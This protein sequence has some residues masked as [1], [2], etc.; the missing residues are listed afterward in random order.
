MFPAKL[1]AVIDYPDGISCIDTEQQR[2][3]LACCYLMRSGDQYAFIECGTSLSVPGLKA[4]LA[5]RGIGLD[6]IAYVIPTHVHLDHAGGVGL[7][8]KDCPNAKLVV[9]PRGARHLIDPSALI[10]GATA[11]YGPENMATMYG[12]ILPVAEDR[13]I[14]ADDNYVLDFNGRK[15]SFIDSPGHARHHF[16][17]WDVQSGGWF[18][19]DTFGLSYRLFDGPNGPFLMPTTTPVQFEPEAWLKTLSRYLAADPAF[20]FLT[21]YGRVDNVAQLAADLGGGIAM[22][23][24]IALHLAEVPDRHARIYEA[25][26]LYSLEELAANASPVTDEVAREWLAFDIELN[27]QGLEVWLDKQKAKPAA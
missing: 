8:M 10:A 11:V 14:V 7:L 6:Q 4:V 27:T 16:S 24:S 21:H 17:I 23:Q 15:L 3:G 2:T 1:P 5:E 18:T 22:Y 19:G 9:H 25:L 20:M 12:E 13:V 26:M